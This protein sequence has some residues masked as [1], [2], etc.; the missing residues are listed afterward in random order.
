MFALVGSKNQV[1]AFR[2]DVKA[3]EKLSTVKL[4]M[5]NGPQLKVV[6]VKEPM[7]IGDVVD[8][9]GYRVKGVRV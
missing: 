6:Q 1:L 7:I 2:N 3:E 8:N 9:N 5:G 4:R